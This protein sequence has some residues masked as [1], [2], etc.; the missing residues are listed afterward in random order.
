MSELAWFSLLVTGYF[1]LANT[2]YLVQMLVGW[3]AVRRRLR[4]LAL[5]DFQEIRD[6]GLAPPISIVVPAYNEGKTILESVRSLLG[7]RYP[8]LEVVVVNDGSTDDTL[9]R[10]IAE[11]GLQRTP[12]VY[13]QR[14]RSQPV[15][16][17]YWSPTWP[18]LWVLDKVNGRKADAANAG[19]NLASAPYVCV[20]DGDSV[21]E[22]DAMP[23]I[24]HAILPRAAETVAAGGTIRIANGCEVAGS[25]VSRVRTP[26]GFLATTQVL[27]YLR[28]F[29][30]GRM[31]WSELDSL[32]IV[33]GAFG[34]FRKDVVV[35]VGGFR[36]DTVGEDMDLVV[37]MHRHMRAAGRPYRVA[38][39]PDPVCW[40]ECPETIR[41]LRNQ[42]ERWQRG[43]GETLD[44]NR[45]MLANRRFGRIGLF[46]VPYLMMF[47]YLA[48]LLEVAGFAILPVGWLLG[49]LDSS[50]FL[51]FV[52]VALAYGLCLSL[53]TL[54]LEELSFRRY[55]E[56]R[57]LLRLAGAAVLENFGLRQLHSWWRLVALLTWRGR[58]Q[59]WQ[60]A[61]RRGLQPAG[62]PS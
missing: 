25:G 10:L 61:P 53:V 26:H 56:P 29:L 32:L 58:P 21:L 22:R 52:G 19:I 3:R 34:V 30:F 51:L 8:R 16:A 60:S 24:M 17:I 1:A 28:A 48:P 13:W 57:D 37:R 18:G 50:L 7:L 31:A 5:E 44:H 46:A 20:V 33:S 47:E 12:R 62:S 23:A 45:E 39:V 54:L 6:S 41:G 2:I 36:H 43:L 59:R 49:L 40:T 42:R 35:E 11:F 15:R 55:R 9:E 14:I 4:G 38:F 27:E